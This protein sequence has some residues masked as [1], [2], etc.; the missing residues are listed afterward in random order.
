MLSFETFEQDIVVTTS[1]QYSFKE[2]HWL[3][4]IS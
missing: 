4:Y 3:V 2:R 1:V